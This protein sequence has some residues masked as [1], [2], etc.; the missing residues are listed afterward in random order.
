MRLARAI[1][2]CIFVTFAVSLSADGPKVQD[3]MTPEEFDASGLHKLTPAELDALNRWLV[4]YTAHEAPLVRQMSPEVKKEV[5]TAT[6][7]PK[8][9]HSQIDG[10]FE[11]WSGKTLFHLK[12]GQTW[13]QRLPGTYRVLLT[14]PEVEI[15]QRALGF[16]WM[17][18]VSTGIS[19][20]VTPAN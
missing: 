17:K 4:R 10:T 12:N 16:Y 19:V 3:L 13:R 6:T 7:A 20:G 18:V 5:A 15:S 14:D 9:I 8:I 1:G 11:G 2:V